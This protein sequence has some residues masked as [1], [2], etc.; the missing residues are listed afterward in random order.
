MKINLLVQ[1]LALID[2]LRGREE[3]TAEFERLLTLCGFDYYWLTLAPKP[4]ES[5]SGLMLAGRWP[6]GWPETYLQKRY[7]QV[8]P[9]VR[10]LGHAQ[11][12]FRWRDTLS[13]FRASPHRKRMERM[14]VDAR[15]NGLE[16][17]YL[18]PVHG[19]RGLVGSLSL[20]GKPVE[21]E[22]VEI[23]LLDSIA[24]RLYWKLVHIENPDMAA[25][26]TAVVDVELTRREM[27]ALSLLAEGMTSPDIGRVLGISSHTVDW[28]MNGIQEKLDARNR[29]HAVAIAF[30]LGLVS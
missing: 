26:L 13:A 4:V 7:M 14:M 30:R 20:G 29:H 11:T 6:R 15:Q 18:F 1:F 28:Y 19:R 24:R 25:R 21:L 27:E 22:G 10:Y 2:E 17:G 8:D 12:G 5:L 3:T 23:G 9:T 16:D